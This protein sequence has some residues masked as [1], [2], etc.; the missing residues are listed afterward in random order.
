MG[1]S[2]QQIGKY[3]LQERLG[4]RERV[5]VWKALDQETQR[6]VAL[7]LVRADPKGD[8]GFVPRFLR[9]SKLLA[10]L[11]HP[12]IARIQDTQL[13]HAPTGMLEFI[14]LVMEY[15][16]GPRLAQYIDNGR[17]DG[18]L[19]PAADVVH[20]INAV[21][22]AIDYAH[23]AGIIHGNLQPDNILFNKLNT[24]HNHLGEP[25]I[26][27]FGNAKFLG[28]TPS[29]LALWGLTSPLYLSPEQSRGYAPAASSDIYALGAI[30]YELYTGKPP[31][32]GHNVSSIML[33]QAHEAPAP[34]ALINTAI[35]PALSA[36]IL[37]CLEK[38]PQQRFPK[39]TALAQALA[40]EL[41]PGRFEKSLGA[42]PARAFQQSGPQNATSF[43]GISPATL[44]SPLSATTSSSQ[45]MPSLS[46]ARAPQP[47][48]P[49]IPQPSLP[50]T[51]LPIPVM[52][53]W[54][55]AKQAT[56]YLNRLGKDS[57]SFI[58][59]IV[60]LALLL[61]TGSTLLFRMSGGASSPPITVGHGYY[62]SSW[63]PG[64]SDSTGM[65]GIN[66][67]VRINLQNFPMP[68]AGK[69]YYAYLL[70]D[71]NQSSPYWVALGPLTLTHG[72]IDV[73][74]P[75]Q[76]QPTDLL[77]NTSRFLLTEEDARNAGGNPFVDQTTWRYYAEIA[78]EPS[79][80]G[81][82]RVID[83]MRDMLAQAPE[84]T[85]IKTTGG[86]SPW[87]LRDVEEIA[88][89]STFA[90]DYWKSTTTL[91]IRQQ[92][93]NILYYLDGECAQAHLQSVP[94]A[95]PTTPSDAIF[96]QNARFA[97][98]NPCAAQAQ[99]QP[100]NLKAMFGNAPDDAL[101]HLLFY[102]QA[103][104]RAPGISAQNRA[105]VQQAIGVVGNL[106]TW[107]AQLRVD[108]LQ[109]INLNDEQFTQPATLKVLGDIADQ[110]RFAFAGHTDEVTRNVQPG[111]SWLFDNLQ[112]LASFD[113]AQYG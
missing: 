32:Q 95:T 1:L 99:A 43:P 44:Q 65:Q 103:V 112:L 70:G 107:L 100:V 48:L 15:I 74:L 85:A 64:Q 27:G 81:G 79:S 82:L 22:K 72:S 73:L 89:W 6:L 55:Q 9:E 86:L 104:L 7:Y 50:Q 57:R 2:Q 53:R 13:F 45:S 36:I 87:L 63:Q 34:P 71:R 88:G 20:L 67:E 68:A 19:P 56:G 5:E 47:S 23:S 113:I 30:L 31:F 49:Q 37:Q 14:Y 26:T 80:S 51:P 91:F 84:L 54:A 109:I 97:L 35:S 52:Q 106:K 42:A 11:L 21:G 46:V 41:L 24:L 40:D 29:T 3:R 96:A 78:Q 92:L 28:A 66:D 39:A 4:G 105:S 90:R 93:V 98:L 75:R 16:N 12:N 18:A 94:S 61:T 17:A 77:Q 102:M 83:Y 110:A 69:R 108:I 76:G 10:A 38:N 62:L 33:Q 8:P 111:A 25:V 101:D 60:I 58:L 59:A